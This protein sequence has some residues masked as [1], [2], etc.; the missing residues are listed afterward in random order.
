M[1][2]LVKIYYTDE[3][4]SALGLEENSLFIWRYN[5]S[6]QTWTKL[7]TNLDFVY[8]TGVNKSENYVWANVTSF[9]LYAIGG[10]KANGQ[11]CSENAECYSGLCCS[12]I[13]QSVCPTGIPPSVGVGVGAPARAVIIP[14]TVYIEFSRMSVLREDIPG[15]SVITGVSVK[16]KGDSRLSGLKVEVSGIP[17]EW[18]TITPKS[19]ELEP[20][21]LGGF[22]IGISV[23]TVVA[24]GDYKVVVT[25]KNQV[26]EEKSFFIL[27]V[28]PYTKEE[29][30]PIVMRIVEID[31]AENK[32][33]VELS[34]YNPSKAWSYTE[35]TELIPKEIANSTD[36][37]EFKTVPTKIIQKDPIVSFELFNLMT[38]ETR[39]IY[40]SVPKILP[41]FTPYIYWPLKELS[42][43]TTKPIS[44]LEIV[45]FKIPIL[46]AG[47]SSIAV[48]TIKNLDSNPHEFGFKMRL[49]SGWETEPKNISETIKGGETRDFRFSIIVP[50]KT[51]SGYYVVR[52]EFLWDNTTIIKEYGVE[53]APFNYLL[54]LI[55][56]IIIGFGLIL[57]YLY[58][59]RKERKEYVRNLEIIKKKIE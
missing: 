45:D 41:E 12:G 33:N 7:T 10:L 2:N 1:W 3:E 27:R 49:P 31:R 21:E 8:G 6:S 40:Y 52:G 23:P 18:T 25:L 47:R 9:S 17:Q 22:T 4:L 57:V 24:F 20:G 26:A 32:T 13:C 15:Q 36:F 51:L 44:G 5:A 54:V 19:L 42:L 30:K 50:E 59:K 55:I 28:K 39:K 35:I 11:Y 48:L 53:V 58:R 46:Y 16:N 34:I 37:V 43:V 38:G 14:P 29:D 56:L